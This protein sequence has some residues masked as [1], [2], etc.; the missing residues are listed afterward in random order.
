MLC[1]VNSSWTFNQLWAICDQWETNRTQSFAV[2]SV[3]AVVKA[4]KMEFRIEC[5]SSFEFKMCRSCK[6]NRFI[7]WMNGAAE[8]D[9][10][11]TSGC[12]KFCLSNQRGFW[13]SGNA[14][15]LP[16]G[17]VCG[18]L[19]CHSIS[20][21]CRAAAGHLGT[22]NAMQIH[23]RS[24]DNFSAS[25]SLSLSINPH[26]EA[27]AEPLNSSCLAWNR[28]KVDFM[29]HMDFTHEHQSI[30]DANIFKKN[31]AYYLKRCK[32]ISPQIFLLK[33]ENG[34]FWCNWLDNRRSIV[35][36]HPGWRLSA[37]VAA[38]G[39][40]STNRLNI[41]WMKQQAINKHFKLTALR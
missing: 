8:S 19:F 9:G 10:K 21:S 12:R 3:L 22:F 35:L 5:R 41:L 14:N 37:A 39:A 7:D 29:P 17:G 38:I 25:L 23:V 34:N 27:D 20:F 33:V 4:T 15:K 2:D 40:W 28:K 16:T 18:S 32:V 1:K 31:E 6:S 13:Q 24:A 11:T 30:F 36:K 26:L